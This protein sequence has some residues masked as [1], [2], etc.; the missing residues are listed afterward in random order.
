MS[1]LIVG[2][3]AFDTIE[4]PLSRKERIVGGS[5]TYCALSASFFTRPRLAAVVGRDFP[6]SILRFL[7]ARGIDLSGLRIK[8]GKTFHWEGRYEEDPNIRT[9]VRT[10]LN[11]FKD[12]RPVLPPSY[13]KADIVFLANLNPDHHAEILGQVDKPR[14][15]AMDTIRLWIETQRAALERELSRV[16]ILFLNDEEAKLVTGERNLVLAGRRL[17]DSGPSLVAVKKGEHGAIVFGKDFTFGVMAHPC[18]RVVDPTGAGDSFAGGFLGYL[19]K[20]GKAGRTEIRRAAVYGSALASFAIE[21][22]GIGR[23]KSLGMGEIEDRFRSF[24][25]LVAF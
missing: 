1:L 9:T 16:D 8:P 11:V 2:S 23:L 6:K 4:T 25:R 10:E 5:G 12:F 13:K 24:K 18:D 15:V 14:L 20:T 22:F 7:R 3:V 21:D 17:L 19:D